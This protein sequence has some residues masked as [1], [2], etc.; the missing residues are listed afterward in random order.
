[1]NHQTSLDLVQKQL[2]IMNQL[3]NFKISVLADRDGLPIAWTCQKAESP[4][5][6]SAA[7]A[8][9]NRTLDQ[10]K[11]QLAWPKIDEIAIADEYGDR[12]VCRT[13]NID[14]QMLSLVVLV[15]KYQRYRRV[16]NQALQIID[17]LLSKMPY[18]AAHQGDEA[19]VA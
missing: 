13:A 4:E 12:L 10:V 16:M 11:S 19:D 7:V 8:L 2:A 14:Q 3:G 6:Y 1:M 17:S 15:P 9:L 18:Y 5:R